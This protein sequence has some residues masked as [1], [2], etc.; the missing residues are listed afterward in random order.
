MLTIAAFG[1]N[2]QGKDYALFFAVAEYSDSKLQ[3]LPQTIQNA[4]K[5][6][7]VLEKQYNFNTEIIENPS[8]DDI[9]TKLN[10]YRKRYANGSLPKDGQFLI[11]FSGHGVKKF[12]NGYFLPADAE[13]D[14]IV[15]TGLSYA[16][17][18]PYISQINCQHI[19]VAVDACY[20]V[21]FDPKWNTMD[22]LSD[23]KRIGE[24]NETQ[25]ILENYRAYKSR[26]FFTSDAREDVVPGR[27]NFARKFLEGLEALRYSRPFITASK[28]FANYIEKAQPSPKGGDFEADDPR[29]A[30]LFFPKVSTQPDIKRYTQ[31]ENEIEAYEAIQDNLSIAA[32]Q[33][34]LNDYPNGIFRTEVYTQ[35][36]QL[37]EEQ[38]WKIARLKNT[39]SSYQHYLINIQM[40]FIL[41][42]Q[43]V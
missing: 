7:E 34:Y 14:R 22:G 36:L 19:L 40:V 31:Q 13:S 33:Q 2:R 28:L 25:R 17:W 24:L 12:E 3:P 5:I 42:K 9:E 4:R 16:I 18:R 38:D 37:Q 1:Q 35:L 15:R 23:F 29:S 11:F 30:F 39:K 43:P 6:A 10:D 41:L 26:V 21:T 32:C 20:S 27:S 8:L